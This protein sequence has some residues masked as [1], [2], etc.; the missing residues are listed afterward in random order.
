MTSIALLNS[1]VSEFPKVPQMPQFALCGAFTA[2]RAYY[3]KV[4]FTGTGSLV[5]LRM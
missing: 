1:H 3:F 2:E 4:N 5:R